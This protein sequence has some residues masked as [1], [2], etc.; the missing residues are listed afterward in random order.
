M[1]MATLLLVLGVQ[2]TME[3]RG[4]TSNRSDYDLPSRLLAQRPESAYGIPS[5]TDAPAYSGGL[6]TRPVRIHCVPRMP[7]D[8]T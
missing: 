7:Q 2:V 3:R 6:G 8:R 4:L 5:T 1:G